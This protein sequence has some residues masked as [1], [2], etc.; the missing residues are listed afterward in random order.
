MIYFEEILNSETK[1]RDL[2]KDSKKV[3]LNMIVIL[4]ENE[5]GGFMFF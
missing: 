4:F 1:C 2:D 3:L 5:N